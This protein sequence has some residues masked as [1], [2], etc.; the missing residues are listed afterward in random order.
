MRAVTGAHSG[1]GTLGYWASFIDRIHL[2]GEQF[3]TPPQVPLLT[4]QVI[5]MSGS[6]SFFV[7][8]TLQKKLLIDDKQDWMHSD[9]ETSIYFIILADSA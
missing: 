9:F 3:Q 1:S 2:S 4:E 6:F 8:K 5:F 7:L